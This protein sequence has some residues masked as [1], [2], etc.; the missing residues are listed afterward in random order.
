MV[1]ALD[2][3][4]ARGAGRPCGS[5]L[6][7]SDGACATLLRRRVGDSDRHPGDSRSDKTAPGDRGGVGAWPERSSIC[8]IRDLTGCNTSTRWPALTGVADRGLRA[9]LRRVAAGTRL[10][11]A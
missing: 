10:P 9:R 4:S 1:A 2:R 11:G 8:A 6:A 3:G 5:F 7:W